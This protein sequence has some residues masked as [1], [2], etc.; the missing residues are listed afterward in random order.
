MFRYMAKGA[1]LDR[2]P[3]NNALGA[4][5]LQGSA[6]VRK[7]RCVKRG[8]FLISAKTPTDCSADIQKDEFYN[9]L[10][11]HVRKIECT[12]IIVTPDELNTQF[13][14]L[15][16]KNACLCGRCPSPDQL[17]NNGQKLL[18]FCKN[19]NVFLSGTNFQCSLIPTVT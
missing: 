10:V 2:I 13:E 14:K 3:I 17:P 6:S 11:V 4:V 16:A 1:L 19:N 8:L 15:S 7:D 18:K 12:D 5:R 9:D